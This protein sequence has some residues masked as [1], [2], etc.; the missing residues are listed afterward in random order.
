MYNNLYLGGS[1]HDG[2]TYCRAFGLPAILLWHHSGGRAML[3][4]P[5]SEL[6][7]MEVLS[8]IVGFIREKHNYHS[9]PLSAHLALR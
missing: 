5:E 3:Y 4:L 7:P 2:I 9:G 8:A 6:L 1:I